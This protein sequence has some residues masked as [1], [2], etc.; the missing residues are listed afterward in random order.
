MH[1]S[2]LEQIIKADY[3][4]SNFNG[5]QWDSLKLDPYVE[6]PTAKYKKTG[7]HPLI[8]GVHKTS[9]KK[10]RLSGSLV[11]LGF[12][13]NDALNLS[14]LEDSFSY[15]VKKSSFLSELFKPDFKS[16][17][18]SSLMLLIA[19]GV[20]LKTNNSLKAIQFLEKYSTCKLLTKTAQELFTLC[21]CLL[22][23]RSSHCLKC[24]L[25]HNSF[26]LDCL[27]IH[28]KKIIATDSTLVL[29]I[30]SRICLQSKSFIDVL[31][32]SCYCGGDCSTTACI[33]AL[34]YH[35]LNID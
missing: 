17:I 9:L 22:S 7:I 34:L 15:C 11:L 33:S 8:E 21:E 31:K 24:H 13:L 12:S 35:C 14:E 16:N 23:T 5:C 3:L 1:N 10:I 32:Y 18:D 26:S 30:C 25:S 27:E 28:K 19:I 29:N 4:T 6:Y 20:Y 2:I